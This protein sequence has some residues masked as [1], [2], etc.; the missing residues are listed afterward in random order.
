MDCKKLQD[1][2]FEAYA[3]GH[4]LNNSSHHDWQ[5]KNNPENNFNTKS[6]IITI[7]RTREYLTCRYFDHAKMC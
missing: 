7:N 6:I 3:D 4:I 1:F 2:Y 5:F